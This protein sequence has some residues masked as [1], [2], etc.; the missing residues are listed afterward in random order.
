MR[1]A[2][3]KAMHDNLDGFY[4][5]FYKFGGESVRIRIVGREL[6]KHILAPFSHLKSDESAM[7]TPQLA[8]DL[9]DENKT[10]IRCQNRSG[11]GNSGWSQVTVTSYDKRFVANKL[12]NTL[13]YY[14][15]QN[16]RIIGSIVWHDRVFI[17]ERAK[18]LARLL[19]EWHNDINVQIIHAGFVSKDGQGILFAGKSG[20]GKSTTSVACICGGLNFLSEDYL[21]LKRHTDGS[22]T[23]YS[24]YNSVFLDTN[25]SARFQK[26]LP[27]IINGRPPHEKKSVIILSK[28]FPERLESLAPVRVVAIVRVLEKGGQMIRAAS[29]AEALMALGPSSLLQIP[30]RGMRAFEKLTEVVEQVPCYWLEVTGDLESIPHCAQEL[31]DKAT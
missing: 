10:N 9:W 1:A 4:Q 26:M 12:P 11:N 20:S 17:Y 28:V 2:F 25:H 18:P 30:S 22:F 6:A 3:D 31:L 21:G 16:R 19:L 15:R 13:A 8:I 27:Y 14:D 23:G 29:K 24:L 7:V 5:S